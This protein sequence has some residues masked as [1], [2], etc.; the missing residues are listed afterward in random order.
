MGL[1][2][3]SCCCR[4]GVKYHGRER[5]SDGCKIAIC[6]KCGSNC[7]V[8]TKEESYAV[9][10]AMRLYH[11]EREKLLTEELQTLKQVTRKLI[12]LFDSDAN[13]LATLEEIDK[14]RLL[15]END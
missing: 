9:N 13:F 11:S 10:K 14:I 5:D 8:C 3:I 6:Q 4:T 7:D 12:K 1:N 15:V 2:R